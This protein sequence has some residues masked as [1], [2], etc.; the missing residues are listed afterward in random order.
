MSFMKINIQLLDG[1]TL[2]KR[3]TAGSAGY[4]LYAA[5]TLTLRSGDVKIVKLGFKIAIPSGF[6][7]QIRSRSGLAAKRVFVLNSPGTIDSDYRNEVG[8]L[9]M[10]LG[11]EEFVVNIGDRIAQM[12]FAKVEVANFIQVDE[13]DL[14]TR[15]DGWGSTGVGSDIG[16][17][18]GK[19]VTCKD[20][21]CKNVL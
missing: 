6:E 19:D 9:L 5:H 2:P 16:A 14:T 1:G 20:V 13:L 3:Q 8:V 18:I 15:A 4:D 17:D 10:N 21:L 12:V 7:A 11:D